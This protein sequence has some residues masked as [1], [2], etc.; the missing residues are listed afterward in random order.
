MKERILE[1]EQKDSIDAGLEL[2]WKNDNQL[3]ITITDDW[4]GDT[5]TGF[6]AS[7]TIELNGGQVEK[8]IKFLNTVKK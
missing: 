8:L 2:R 6:G 3:E 5:E 4:Y 1:F 7:L